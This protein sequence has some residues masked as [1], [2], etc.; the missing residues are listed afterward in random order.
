MM[1]MRK[2]FTF[3]ILCLSISCFAKKQLDI[4]AP[5]Y[6]DSH[7]CGSCDPEIVWN[8]ETKQWMIFYTARR[9]AL[10]QSSACGTPIGVCISNDMKNW[11]FEGY[12]KFDGEGGKPDSEHTFWAP[13]CIVK[14]GVIHMFVTYKEDTTPPWG[15]GGCIMHYTAPVNDYV[16]G[17]KRVDV[18]VDEDRCLD[19]SIIRLPSG[20]YRMYYV[21]G[22]EYMQNNKKMI[23][24]AES[25]DLYT[26]EMKGNVQGDVNNFKLHSLPYQEAV[27][28]FLYRNRFYMLTDPHVGLATYSSDDGVNWKYH[29]Q[30]LKAGTSDRTLDWS[31]GRHPSVY[32]NKK[33][34]AFIFYHVEPFREGKEAKFLEKHQRYTFLQMARLVCGKEGINVIR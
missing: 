6:A 29:G 33:N 17:W 23:R 18:V 10:G 32:V 31:Q 8:P 14:D 28:V 19:A 25:K 20:I 27:Y 1:F 12:C 24:Y 3:I 26:W 15:T 4:P 34:E 7:Y 5:I 22:T 11:K 30:I 21:S 2:I 16:N 13:G 9:P